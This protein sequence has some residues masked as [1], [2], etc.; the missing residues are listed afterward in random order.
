MVSKEGSGHI[1][2]L[3]CAYITVT[4]SKTTTFQVSNR[5]MW[6][7]SHTQWLKKL[8]YKKMDAYPAY[9]VLGI[10][11]AGNLLLISRGIEQINVAYL[12][13]CVALWLLSVREA[14]LAAR[15]CSIGILTTKK[16]PHCCRGRHQSSSSSSGSSSGMSGISICSSLELL[17]SESSPRSFRFRVRVALRFAVASLSSLSYGIKS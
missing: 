10:V 14:G 7:Y 6:F 13:N 3:G 4:E 16:P 15:G 5:R 17:V 9:M 1:A 2:V 11:L 12:L 8:D